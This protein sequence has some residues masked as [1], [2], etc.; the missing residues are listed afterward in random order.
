MRNLHESHIASMDIVRQ[1][2][3]N[4]FGN[5]LE[6]KLSGMHSRPK[7]QPMTTSSFLTCLIEIVIV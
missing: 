1:D 4:R 6:G 2:V 7:G 3:K 5:A